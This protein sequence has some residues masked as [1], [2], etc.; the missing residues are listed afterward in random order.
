[1]TASAAVWAR[2]GYIKPP[3]PT[4]RRC[5]RTLTPEA[6]SS[7]RKHGLKVAS[8]R[9]MTA[10]L[11]VCVRGIAMRVEDDHASTFIYLLKCLPVR[12]C[13]FHRIRSEL[14]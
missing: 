5:A 6:W 10:T 2:Y 9:C 13:H 7:S 12:G 1:M 4:P 8:T 14:Q 11:P 3:G